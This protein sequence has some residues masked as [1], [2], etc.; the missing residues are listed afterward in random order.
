M[1]ARP[2]PLLA[3][4]KDHVTYPEGVRSA[5]LA[6]SPTPFNQVSTIK[7]KSMWWSNIKL[8]IS[9]RFTKVP[10]ERAL[11]QPIRRELLEK[12]DSE[13]DGRMMGIVTRLALL[14]VLLALGFGVR[15]DEIWT[16]WI[17][18]I[19]PIIFYLRLQWRFL[20]FRSIHKWFGA[21]IPR[22]HIV[23]HR[24]YEMGEIQF[25]RDIKWSLL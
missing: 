18:W 3:R 21:W 10:I 15:D 17:C 1:I 16:T 19:W 4:G 9:D 7:K 8:L 5:I 13:K 22:L 23:A 25:F 11:K 2:P 12:R 20:H 24:E 14:S 6:S